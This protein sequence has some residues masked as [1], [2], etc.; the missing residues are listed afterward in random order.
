M[1]KPPFG[2]IAWRAGAIFF[3]LAMTMLP[4]SAERYEPTAG[5]FVPASRRQSV[6]PG[7]DTDDNTGKMSDN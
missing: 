3:F 5:S 1:R 6:P 2:P 7:L 4:S